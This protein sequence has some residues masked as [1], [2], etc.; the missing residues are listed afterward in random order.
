[1]N[2]HSPGISSESVA[3]PDEEPVAAPNTDTAAPLASSAV[4]LISAWS[5]LLNLE[6]A[7]ARRSLRWLLI[8]AIAIPVVALGAWIGLG[9]LLVAAAHVYTH[10]WLLA[11]LLGASVQLLVFAIL[12]HLIR[13]WLRDLSLPQSRKAL[14]RAMERMS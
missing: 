8:G 13:R 9:A 6:L 11:L 5:S 3:R 1:M 14:T 4:N 2:E 7:L 12:L 10:S